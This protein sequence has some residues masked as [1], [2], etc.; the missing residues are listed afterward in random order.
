VSVPGSCPG[1]PVVGEEPSVNDMDDDLHPTIVDEEHRLE[2][3]N[4]AEDARILFGGSAAINI[5]NDDDVPGAATGGQTSTGSTSPTPT[6]TSTT[7]TS[8]SKRPLR[9]K[10]WHD[11]DE[12]THLVNGKM[13]WYGA[14]CKYC[15]VTL[16]G[17]SSSGTG[18]LLRHNCLAKKE[19]QCAGIV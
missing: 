6:G 10:V 18:H 1:T 3:H 12:P 9:S 8:S 7:A 13:V 2:Y 15:K 11:F 14:I 4:K 19:Q 17:K 16:S 5:D